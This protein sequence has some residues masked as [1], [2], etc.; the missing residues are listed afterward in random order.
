M[1]LD[2]RY[3]ARGSPKRDEYVA[4]QQRYDVANDE[5]VRRLTK[6]ID[7]ARA[8]LELGIL[9]RFNYPSLAAMRAESSELLLLIELESYGEKHFEQ[10]EIARMKAEAEMHHG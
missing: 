10:L 5:N 2:W 6:P 7:I 8:E 1:G 4:W 9:E 3:L